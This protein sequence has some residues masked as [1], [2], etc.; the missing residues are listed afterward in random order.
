[1]AGGDAGHEMAGAYAAHEMTGGCAVH[2]PGSGLRNAVEAIGGVYCRIA[3]LPPGHN[4]GAGVCEAT[5][6]RQRGLLALGYFG[7]TTLP[8]GCGGESPSESWRD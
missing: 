1:M 2:E 5:T 6:A 8:Q 4:P 3:W 7:S